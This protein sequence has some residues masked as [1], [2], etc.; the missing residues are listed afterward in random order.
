[1]AAL[2]RVSAWLAN[3]PSS[4]FLHAHAWLMYVHVVVLLAGSAMQQLPGITGTTVVLVLGIIIAVLLLI[5]VVG[6][7]I[8]VIAVA[9]RKNQQK[10][11]YT[12]K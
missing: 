4:C 5:I 10:L 3:T 7:V 1:M 12:L 11:K 6:V 9:V 8:V 2:V